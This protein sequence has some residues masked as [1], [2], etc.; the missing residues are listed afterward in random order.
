MAAT[1]SEGCDDL[2][3]VADEGGSLGTAPG[4]HGARGYRSVSL[5]AI[6]RSIY[7][8]AVFQSLVPAF[9]VLGAL[10]EHAD[11][12]PPEPEAVVASLEP[13]FDPIHFRPRQST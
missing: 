12:F 1:F 5:R 4:P 9:A 10:S 7:R 11:T 6:C 8:Y 3:T 13:Q 2:Q